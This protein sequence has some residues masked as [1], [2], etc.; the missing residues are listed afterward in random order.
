MFLIFMEE[1]LQKKACRSEM[2]IY[3][4]YLENFQMKELEETCDDTA[5]I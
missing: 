4:E 1:S 3:G 2:G 5:V